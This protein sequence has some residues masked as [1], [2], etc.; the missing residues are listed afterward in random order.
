MHFSQLLNLSI[1]YLL[2]H[3]RIYPQLRS[4]STRNLHMS[5]LSCLA[6]C[7]TPSLDPIITIS[8]IFDL[9]LMCF[10]VMPP[11]TKVSDLN[12]LWQ[13]HY[14][15]TCGLLWTL[16]S[17]QRQSF[18]HNKTN[19]SILSFSITCSP[20]S[21]PFLNTNPTLKQAFHFASISTSPSPLFAP[22]IHAE[23]APSQ[24]LTHLH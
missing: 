6:A 16:V 3:C 12:F 17:F 23:P 9:S 19:S 1:T 14:Y 7:V 24:V 8:L 22:S 10:W 18:L 21:S 2:L 5:P 13:S 4:C 20:H 15:Q 11:T